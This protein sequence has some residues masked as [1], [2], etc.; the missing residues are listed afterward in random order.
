MDSPTVS[1]LARSGSQWVEPENLEMMPLPQG[2][3][4]VTLPGYLPIGLDDKGEIFLIEQVPGLPAQG[5]VFAVA[6]LL[7]Q[8]FTRT[9]LPAGVRQNA[10]GCLPVYGYAAVGFRN[11]KIYVAAIKSDEHRKWHPKNYNTSNLE[12]KIKR[13]T[14]RYPNN[15]ILHQL[16]RCSLQ[17]GCYTAQNIFYQR[18][19][20]GIPTMISCNAD[21]LG[22]I[23]ENHGPFD[24]PQ[25]RLTFLPEVDEI[26]QIGI[27]HLQMARDAIISFGQGCEGEPSLNATK[28]ALAIKKIREETSLG[29]I[30]MNTNA[31]YTRGIRQMCDA[32][33][34]SMRV[35]IF[36][37]RED[38][39]LSYHRPK[40]YLLTDVIN[41]I[42]YAKDKGLGISLNL[43]VFPGFTDREEEVQALLSFVQGNPVDMI[44][45][46]NLNIDADFLMNNLR[47]D[48]PGIG[49]GNFIKVLRQEVP[50]VRLGSY[51]HPV[52]GA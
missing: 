20:G 33:L 28:L 17:Y 40:D 51:S 9:L 39:Y 44:Q 14:H 1:M 37:C 36:S 31:G 25:N 5:V 24:S 19:E 26:A 8:G 47:G 32:G 34:D 27:E 43:L 29:T 4:L 16:S 48:S 13:L 46:R 45:L 2:A 6:A 41:S 35:T 22:C 50:Q 38:N 23:S 10:S 30:N 11:E 52:S 49:I 3:T 12:A 7:P 42:H 15:R 18:W 21:C